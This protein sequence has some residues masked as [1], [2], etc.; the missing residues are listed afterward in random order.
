MTDEIKLEPDNL[1]VTIGGYS[2]QSWKLA[3]AKSHLI[4]TIFDQEYE[5][6]LEEKIT[7]E[8]EF[9]RR[10]WASLDACGTWDW[11]SYYFAN[12]EEST[13]WTVEILL[14]DG[15]YIDTGGSSSFPGLAE[16]LAKS[17]SGDR[18]RRGAP[19]EGAAEGSKE[20]GGAME[21]AFALF[22]DAIRELIG[23]REFFPLDL[24]ALQGQLPRE[25]V[26]RLGPPVAPQ[27]SAERTGR[28]RRSGP[29]R[30][31]KAKEETQNATAAGGPRKGG[32]RRRGGAAG[33]PKPGQAADGTT[34]KPS[35]SAKEQQ[36][37]GAGPRAAGS[38]RRRSRRRPAGVGQSGGGER[39]AA[40][41]PGPKPPG[42]K[43][44]GSKPGADE[45]S[46]AKPPEGEASSR[47]R[48]RGRRGG[49]R[50]RP[51]GEGGGG[52]GEGAAPG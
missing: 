42:A 38:S 32:S 28:G 4:Y 50:G 5:S 21:G 49:R 26:E 29:A 25:E 12:A 36:A 45:G 11:D 13:S 46:A 6:R 3:W 52:G 35:P 34:A 31:G 43:P 48:R 39:P 33:R 7:P 2:R 9:W 22:L 18:R 14:K 10:F 8:P 37:A 16:S 44:P 23:G 20:N 27:K 47:R 24:A 1:V 19:P 17:G 40:Q 41:S 51:G 15:R 30:G